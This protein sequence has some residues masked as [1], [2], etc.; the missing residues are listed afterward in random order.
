MYGYGVVKN[1]YYFFLKMLSYLNLFDDGKGL[2]Y[3][4]AYG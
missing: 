2:T 4:H 1:K 3:F